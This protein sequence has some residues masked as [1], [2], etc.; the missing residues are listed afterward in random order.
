MLQ[1][2]S[3]FASQDI[4]EVPREKVVAYTRALQYWM[5]QNDLPTGGKPRSLAK[6]VLE[7]RKEV[8][9]YLTF[10]DE[11]VFQGVTI[12]EAEDEKSSTTSSSADTP[13]TPPVSKPQPKERTPKFASW[14]KV[15]HPPQPMVAARETLQ[16]TQILR[17]RGRCHLLSQMTPVRSLVHR[18]KA[19]SLP[20]PS[21]PARALMLVKPSTPPQGFVGVTVCLKLPE[22]V[23]IDQEVPGGILSIGL[24]TTP[25]ISSISSSHVIR[26]DTTGL[27]YVDTVTTS[28]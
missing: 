15:V 3:I 28:I 11:E 2:Y 6:S 9:W 4:R 22:P 1:A 14:Y 27:T 16:P 7:L 13:K 10:N 24:V 20:E 26:D 23:E 5:E 8:R 19:P 25:E 21:P 17:P 18:P 12:P